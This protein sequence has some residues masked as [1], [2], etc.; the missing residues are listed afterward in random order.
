LSNKVAVL[1]DL[2]L[3]GTGHRAAA[4]GHHLL[5][6]QSQIPISVPSSRPT[7]PAS[8]VPHTNTLTH[9]HTRPATREPRA[10]L[11][12]GPLFPDKLYLCTRSVPCGGGTST[13]YGCSHAATKTGTAGSVGSR[14]GVHGDV[15][16]LRPAQ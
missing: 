3:R 15:G 6:P 16:I 2:L 5:E 11:A 4:T 9:S 14:T 1:E 7:L 13:R 10:G 8:R 12:G